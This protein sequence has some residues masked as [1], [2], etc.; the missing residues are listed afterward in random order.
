MSNGK[1]MSSIVELCLVVKTKYLTSKNSPDNHID[2]SIAGPRHTVMP[3]PGTISHRNSLSPTL[4]VAAE[5]TRE[6]RALI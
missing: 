1:T 2:H 4:V 3:F 6:F 5:A